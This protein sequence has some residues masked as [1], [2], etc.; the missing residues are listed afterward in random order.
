ME[1]HAIIY[2]Q[3]LPGLQPTSYL[4]LQAAE[5]PQPLKMHQEQI[6]L[7]PELLW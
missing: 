1:W 4:R 7:Q 2:Q 6:L 5:L 3:L